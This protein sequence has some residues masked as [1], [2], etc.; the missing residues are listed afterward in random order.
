MTLR[1]FVGLLGAVAALT[2]VVTMALS[3]EA[4]YISLFGLSDVNCGRVLFPADYLDGAARM[5]CD[6][7]VS[8]R[9]EWTVP[10][11]VVGLVVL[12]GAVVVKP[13]RG[14]AKPTGQ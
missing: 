14:A 13:G 4:E 5:A 3:V 2:A 6:D 11:G 9:R 8:D 7:A 1:Q 12:A 10:L